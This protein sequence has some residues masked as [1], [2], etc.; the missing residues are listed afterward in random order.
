MAEGKK[1]VMGTATPGGGFPAYGWPYAEV[2][3]ATD[4]SLGIEPIPLLAVIATCL[5]FTFIN[6]YSHQS[7]LMVM[8]PGGYSTRSFVRFGLPIVLVSM[9]ATAAIASLL[10]TA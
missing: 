7:N 10:L 9:V 1:L 3:N 2:L 4:P 8:G 5:A 6:P